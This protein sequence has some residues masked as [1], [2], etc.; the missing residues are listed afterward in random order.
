M[1]DRWFFLTLLLIKIGIRGSSCLRIGLA[2]EWYDTRNIGCTR[3]HW[4]WC[5]ADILQR[6]KWRWLQKFWQYQ[7]Q[8]SHG[9]K[10]NYHVLLERS[11]DAL[12]L[13]TN[14]E[15]CLWTR[16]H[17]SSSR[18]TVY[19]SSSTYIRR[20][21]NKF[22]SRRVRCLAYRTGQRPK[23]SSSNDQKKPRM[24]QH[25]WWGLRFAFN[26][27]RPMWSLVSTDSSPTSCCTFPHGINANMRRSVGPLLELSGCVH[28]CWAKLVLTI[29]LKTLLTFGLQKK[30][31]QIFLAK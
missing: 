17:R 18:K 31:I 11:R 21:F 15:L 25:I 2:P 6:R 22:A 14:T 30:F 3:Y 20:L 28:I 13:F 10:V 16:E 23:I 19:T 9:M 1:N 7:G 8:S 27:P 24:Y 12:S 4:Y 29:S 5:K 26:S